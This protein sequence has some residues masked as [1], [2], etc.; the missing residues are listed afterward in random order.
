MVPGAA[1]SA[2]AEGAKEALRGIAANGTA[3][4]VAGLQLLPMVQL[5]LILLLRKR[6]SC[7]S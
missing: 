1:I 5:L 6:I 2:G 3:A 7:I 4:A